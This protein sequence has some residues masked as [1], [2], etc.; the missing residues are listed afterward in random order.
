MEHVDVEVLPGFE[1]GRC[2]VGEDVFADC[3]V[4]HFVN[5][6]PEPYR[7]SGSDV[8]GDESL[9][10]AFFF[11]ICHSRLVEA[12]RLHVQTNLFERLYGQRLV[13]YG[14]LF[15]DVLPE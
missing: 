11:C 4:V 3:V 10:P 13:I 1:Q 6:V 14:G 7:S 12:F 9:V 5:D 15:A 2:G 8:V